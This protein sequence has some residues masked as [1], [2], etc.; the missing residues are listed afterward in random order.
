MRAYLEE[1]DLK[2]R[3]NSRVSVVMTAILETDF[4]GRRMQKKSF[5]CFFQGEKYRKFPS[6]CRT[7]FQIEFPLFGLKRINLFEKNEVL[8]SSIYGKSW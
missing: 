4:G 1:N 6:G 3:V 7:C 8:T 5:I 2:A